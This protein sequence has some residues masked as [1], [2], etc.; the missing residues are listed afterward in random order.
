MN[1]E[2]SIE[3][4]KPYAEKFRGALAAAL[5]GADQEWRSVDLQV[6][7]AVGIIASAIQAA[8]A[9]AYDEAANFLHE[10]K[11]VLNGEDA[12]PNMSE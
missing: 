6:S 9:E 2:Q 10:N 3:A 8:K 12:D 1:D 5:K 11:T 4:A 7:F